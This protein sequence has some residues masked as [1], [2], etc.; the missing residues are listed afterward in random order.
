MTMAEIETDFCVVGG[1]PA[2]LTLALLLA[3]SGAR[4][5]VL[6]RSRTLAREYRGDILQ[7]G[8]MTLLD[9]LGV[10]AGARRRGSHEHDRFLL[11]EGDQVLI[12]GDYRRLPGPFNCLLSIPQRH[13]LEELLEHCRRHDNLTYLAGSR[14]TDLITDGSTVRGAVSSGPDGLDRVRALCVI[15]ADGR[16]SKVRRLAGIDAGRLDVFDQDVLWF[17]V[18]ADGVL[19]DHVRISRGGGNPVLA[20][21]TVPDSVQIGWTLPHGAY[22]RMTAAGFE[23]LRDQICAAVPDYADQIRKHI[24]GLKDL[25]LLDVFSGNA[26]VWVRDGLV[27]IGDSAHTLS[28]VGAQGVNLA[29]QDAVAL[30]PVLMAALASH[31]ASAARLGRFVARRK[32]AVDRMLRL[33]RMQSRGMLSNGALV[34]YL[35]PRLA[36]LMNR[37]PLYRRILDQIAF[38]DRRLHISSD[39]FVAEP[40]RGE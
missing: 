18:P 33:Q 1:G 17:R 30:H 4:V 32:P 24:T 15:G 31:D 22:P 27:L 23:H 40:A 12:D 16:Y 14:V 28:P 29:I 3:R 19:P 25:T 9:E 8:G 39:L 10:L 2:G 7:P 35:R 37:S 13:I 20:Y 6:E 21:A 11:M 38:G 34:S 26:P 36:P 5:T